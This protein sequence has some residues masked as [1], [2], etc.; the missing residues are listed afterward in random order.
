MRKSQ[1]A[2]KNNPFWAHSRNVHKIRRYQKAKK[3]QKII[4]VLAI[5]HRSQFNFT[6]KKNKNHNGLK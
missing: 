6:I 5:G 4:E 2:L 1:T 3:L